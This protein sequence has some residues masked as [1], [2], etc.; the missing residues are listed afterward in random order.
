ML[1]N[2]KMQKDMSQ[3]VPY[4]IRIRMLS[5]MWSMNRSKYI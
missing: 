5:L 1:P 3:S 2:E 4:K